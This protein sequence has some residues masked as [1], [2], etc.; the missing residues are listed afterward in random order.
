MIKFS[1]FGKI[2]QTF[3]EWRDAFEYSRYVEAAFDEGG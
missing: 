3:Q 1:F 2:A